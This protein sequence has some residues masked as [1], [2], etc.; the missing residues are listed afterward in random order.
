M[1]PYLD[2]QTLAIVRIDPAAMKVE[3][4]I[5]VLDDPSQRQPGI[6]ERQIEQA[7][8]MVGK[9]TD[10]Q[11]LVKE[12]DLVFRLADLPQYPPFAVIRMQPGAD[13]KKL[14]ALATRMDVNEVIDEAQFGEQM[15]VSGDVVVFGNERAIYRLK[16]PSPTP[17]PNLEQAFALAGD[18]PLQV[19][20]VPTDIVRQDLG[21]MIP[22]IPAE[23]GIDGPTI[24]HS[25]SYAAL[26]LKPAPGFEM[27]I[28]AQARDAASA[29]QVDAAIS[30][31]FEKL[32][33]LF[34]S[35]EEQLIINAFRPKLED[36]RFAW[37]MREE[38]PLFKKLQEQGMKNLAEARQRAAAGQPPIALPF[39][40]P[41]DI[42]GNL[43][44]VPGGETV[45]D[46]GAPSTEP[47]FVAAARQAFAE[48][49]E[50]DGMRYVYAEAIAGKDEQR[51]KESLRWAPALKRPTLAIRWGVGIQYTAPRNF[52]GNPAPIGRPQ[53]G[54]T[55]PQNNSGQQGGDPN[56]PKPDAP[57]L[58]VLDYFTAELGTKIV[59]GLR[60]RVDVGQFGDVLNQYR[61]G[62]PVAPPAD[63]ANKAAVFKPSM[64]APGVV[65]IGV[66]RGGAAGQ[67]EL[68]TTAKKEGLDALVIFDINV[69]P[70]RNFIGNN[71]KMMLWDVSKNEA[72]HSSKIL[73][74][75][76]VEVAR[77]EAKGTDPVEEVMERFF[78]V[79]DATYMLDDLPMQLNETNVA[80]RVQ[81]LTE[82]PPAEKLPLLLEIT[83]WQ[84]RGLLSPESAAVAY[85]KLLGP[86]GAKL[87]GTP[88]ERMSV[89]KKL[90]PK[91]GPAIKTPGPRIGL[92]T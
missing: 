72:L 12:I 64:I 17:V 19:L 54:Q 76:A 1:A 30:K 53:A 78:A 39:G 6:D 9:L 4:I 44:Q 57:P 49:K 73:K 16:S 21:R 91:T 28:K 3:D 35:V 81:K 84:Q 85:E 86:D 46:E 59:D 74:N 15:I 10:L 23:F 56:M 40:S 27:H 41:P 37:S 2:D 24:T 43:P 7:K 80:A 68:M 65:F 22:T 13:A 29:Q 55:P 52:A 20:F 11:A 58:T 25:I 47:P 42:A 70:S 67:K 14:Y 38:D 60:T 62:S 90:L 82:T 8:Q 51:L 5:K 61:D 89:M 83:F 18:A 26:A 36:D 92:G 45:P 33:P 50:S 48:G 34:N 32:Q 87:L 63:D 77:K 79:V 75:T 66:E 69:S 88:E 71:T 31:G